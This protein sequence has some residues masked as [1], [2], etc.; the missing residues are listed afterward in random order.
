AKRTMAPCPTFSPG[1]HQTQRLCCSWSRRPLLQLFQPLCQLTMTGDEALEALQRSAQAAFGRALREAAEHRDFRHRFA[2]DEAQA[3]DNALLGWQPTDELQRR[4]EKI[5]RLHLLH[6]V[7]VQL[8]R[9]PAQP[10]PAL[11][12]P[13]SELLVNRIYCD[14]LNPGA[15]LVWISQR[16]V[17]QQ[18]FQEDLLHHVVV[19]GICPEQAP[20]Q[21]VHLP[22]KALE[23]QANTELGLPLESL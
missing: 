13:P 17:L 14:H 5:A 19:L 7:A 20:Y 16:V 21:L 22:R 6:Q 10:Q 12:L 8:G 9:S 23:E 3:E 11:P 18:D 1:V 4:Q 15:E 2:F